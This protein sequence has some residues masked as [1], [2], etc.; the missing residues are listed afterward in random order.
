MHTLCVCTYMILLINAL[1]ALSENCKIKNIRH[2]D[3]CAL[4]YTTTT[5]FASLCYKAPRIES[6]LGE[7]YPF[8]YGVRLHVPRGHKPSQKGEW[9]AI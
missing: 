1:R 4:I 5:T 2:D 9:V 6:P 8:L 3:V 7:L